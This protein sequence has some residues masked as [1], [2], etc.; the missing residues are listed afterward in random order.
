MATPHFKNIL[1]DYRKDKSQTEKLL[2]T[3]ATQ[4]RYE[5]KQLLLMNSKCAS[6]TLD[7]GLLATMLVIWYGESLDLEEMGKIF[8]LNKVSKRSLQRHIFK[9]MHTQELWA[10]R[11]TFCTNYVGDCIDQYLFEARLEEMELDQKITIAQSDYRREIELVPMLLKSQEIQM[12]E[13][14]R[15]VIEDRCQWTHSLFINLIK[16]DPKDADFH[17]SFQA[18][19]SEVFALKEAKKISSDDFC[20][21]CS[22]NI[23]RIEWEDSQTM[24]VELFRAIAETRQVTDRQPKD[25]YE[26]AFMA[27]DSM[28]VIEAKDLIQIRGIEDMGLATPFMKMVI[29]DDICMHSEVAAELALL[30]HPE[31]TEDIISKWEGIPEVKK[32][33]LWKNFNYYEEELRSNP[34]DPNVVPDNWFWPEE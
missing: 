5:Y 20:S 4:D 16:M 17:P 19:V 25:M 6:T 13:Q 32:A 23:D 2:E 28:K 22:L 12:N 1:E 27:L 15:A 33:Q 9:N 31:M 14:L 7:A 29:Q 34:K 11:D 24:P 18:N 21:W 30:C 8:A 26:L 3:V 10:K